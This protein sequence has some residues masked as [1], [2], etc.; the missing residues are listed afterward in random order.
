MVDPRTKFP[1][2][3]FAIVAII[4]VAAGGGGF[5][6]L[7]RTVFKGTTVTPAL[8]TKEGDN[9]T[10][11][12]IGIFGS[13]ID[14]G[15]VFDTSLLSVADDNSTFPKALSFSYRG[16]SGYVPL[17]AHVGPETYG[18]YTSLIQGFW[19]AMVGVPG[20]QT[21]QTV[22]PPAQG[23]GFPNP[24]QILTLPLVQSVPIVHVY[25]PAEFGT[26]FSGMSA[27][28]GS[29]F[30][31]PHWG[32]QDY[33]FSV[34]STAVVLL[35]QPTVGETIHPL[36]WTDTVLSVSSAQGQNGNITYVNDLVPQSVG[37]VTGSDWLNGGSTYYLT[38]VDPAAG[39]YTLDFNT[40]VT[41]NTLIF[42]I[43]IVNILPPAAS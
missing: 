43:T 20:N 12:Y 23:Y 34:N 16:A 25:T 1:W 27:Q 9:V 15:K 36:D 26:T 5:Y 8:I 19:T 35:Y 24:A 42:D 38:D 17:Q 40:E 30:T 4:I 22:I 33:V 11:N 32:W 28:V 41:G 29:T 18:S 10:V 3:T 21:V 6:V 14:K 13:G 39:T 7:T 37:H 2:L 31:D